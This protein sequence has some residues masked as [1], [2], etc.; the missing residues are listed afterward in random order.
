MDDYAITDLVANYDKDTY[1]SW[2]L[3]YIQGQLW[4]FFRH[5]YLDANL[6]CHVYAYT[7]VPASALESGDLS[8]DLTLADTPYKAV[9]R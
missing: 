5:T 6:P 7:T 2:T 3:Q 4:L 8:V 1:G 9:I